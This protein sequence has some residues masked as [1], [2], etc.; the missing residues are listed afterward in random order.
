MK[1][2]LLAAWSLIALLPTIVA[3]A[4][5][6]ATVEVLA[7]G[8]MGGKIPRSD[9]KIESFHG[10][11]FTGPTRDYASKFH[12]GQARD[13]PFGTYII[14]ANSPGFHTE[15]R[16]VGIYQDKATVVL[17][18]VVGEI[19]G[20]WYNCPGRALQGRLVGDP[21]KWK[22]A[23]IKVTG[24]FSSF[25]A[26]SQVNRDGEFQIMAPPPGIF[27]VFVVNQN[28]VIASHIFIASINPSGSP[29]EIEI[30]A[31]PVFRWRE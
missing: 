23:I 29:L 14:R 30:G 4:D 22:D 19:D 9:L 21:Q 3:A 27:A 24:V 15:E 7:F 16:L 26:E 2:K 8:T 28:A 12:G 5:Q 31:N 17:G 10:S 1:L 11:E 25:S 13:I 20:C 6:T 18:L